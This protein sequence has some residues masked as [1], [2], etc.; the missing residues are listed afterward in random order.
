MSSVFDCIVVGSGHA[1]SCAALS[2]VQSGCKRV[3]IVEKAPKEWAGGNGYFTAGAH[4]TVHDGLNDLLPIVGNVTK[5]L[6]SSIEIDPYKAED[7]IGD[8]MRLS[9]NKSDEAL[10]KEVVHNSRQTI[11]WLTDDVGVHFTLSFNRQ[12]YYVNGKYRFWGGLALGVEDGGKGLIG[13]EHK[14]LEDAGIE[15]WYGASASQLLTDAGSGAIT[16]LRI[17]K[18]GKE[19][20]LKSHAVILACGGFEASSLMRSTYLG[21]EWLRARVCFVSELELIAY[22]IKTQ[23]R[24]VE[25]PLIPVTVL[26]LLKVL[27]L[28]YLETG[29]AAVVTARAG[30][31][32]RTLILEIV[33]SATST[34]SPDIHSDLCLIA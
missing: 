18:E 20:A 1:G 27:V 4:R 5:E 6:A 9:D 25:P 22:I 31:Q 10:V 3:L 17:V 12:A 19:T 32:M 33:F 7:F 30:T 26:Q 15:I 23:T 28:S 34:Q 29:A 8:I 14:A 13:T 2:A 11:Q 16:G 24:S 21:E